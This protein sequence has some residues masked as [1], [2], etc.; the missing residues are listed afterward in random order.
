MPDPDRAAPRIALAFDFGRRRIGMAAPEIDHNPA[1]K[2]D[3]D[4]AAMFPAFGETA[5]IGIPHAGE[6]RI[7]DSFGDHGFP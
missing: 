7:A 4:A 1:A 3:G 2:D 5:L 6:A